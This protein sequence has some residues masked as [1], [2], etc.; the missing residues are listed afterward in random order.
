MFLPD[1][2]PSRRP[3]LPELG[4]SIWYGISELVEWWPLLRKRLKKL[5]TTKKNQNRTVSFKGFQQISGSLIWS[6]TWGLGVKLLSCCCWAVVASPATGIFTGK[7]QKLAKLKS[8][9]G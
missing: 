7:I 1:L 8:S 9:L 6:L 2:F 3:A 4:R 5:A